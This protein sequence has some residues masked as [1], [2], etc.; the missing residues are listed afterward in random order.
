MRTALQ[1]TGW[2]EY[3]KQ[4]WNPVTKTNNGSL[5]LMLQIIVLK[6]A[7]YSFRATVEREFTIGNNY[8]LSD[9]VIWKLCVNS[10]RSVKEHTVELIK[11]G[12]KGFY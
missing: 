11:S 6:F 5:F 7:G 8:S 2:M 9:E 3:V 4:S 10:F 12:A 1:W